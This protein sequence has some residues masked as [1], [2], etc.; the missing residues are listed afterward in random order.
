MLPDL[1]TGSLSTGTLPAGG[2]RK[3]SRQPLTAENLSSIV[4]SKASTEIRV[5]VYPKPTI[6]RC[7]E[8]E[9]DQADPLL[10]S[11]GRWTGGWIFVLVRAGNRHIWRALLKEKRSKARH[12]RC[13]NTS[14]GTTGASSARARR[15][16]GAA[17]VRCMRRTRELAPYVSC[18]ARKI[19]GL[20]SGDLALAA[21]PRRR[22]PTATINNV[23]SF[24]QACRFALFRAT[25]EDRRPQQI[26]LA[27]CASTRYAAALPQFTTR[28]TPTQRSTEESRAQFDRSYILS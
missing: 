22:T 5:A 14:R 8:N 26:S 24:Q 19:M 4:L 15:A 21:V 13:R 16:L 11:D 6:T 10:A 23:P 28:A 18:W 25:A 2:C 17:Q 3:Y 27:V 9:A 12:V 20:V 1:G 7:D